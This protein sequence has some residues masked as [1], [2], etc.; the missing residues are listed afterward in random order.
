MTEKQ[1]VLRE[2]DPD[3]LS[4]ARKLV[5]S[6]RF[7]SLAV[8]DRD[9]GFP[10]VSRALMATDLDGTPLI[11]VS[12]LASHTQSLI[13]DPRCSL[14][15]GEVGKGD[16]LAHPRITLFA[17]AKQVARDTPEHKRARQRFLNRH[18]KASLYIDFPDFSFFRLEPQHASL[19]GGFGRAYVLDGEAFKIP[20]P[21]APEDWLRL[22]E[23]IMIKYRDA[24][25]LAAVVGA[26]K[27]S[28]Y[29]LAGLDPAGFN[30]VS[31]SV[32]F[33]YEFLLG[34]AEPL[35][36]EAQLAQILDAVYRIRKI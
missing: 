16:P 17:T 27:A 35:P 15:A 29:H 19:N 12:A 4:L 8:Q 28:G 34:M 20:V 21:G 18:P 9:S 14:L 13:A 36:V 1:N 11:L 7:V 31:G 5:R 10:A 32:S 23:D 33:R 6:A 24:T 2:L 25:Q 22:E 30:L 3:G 26:P